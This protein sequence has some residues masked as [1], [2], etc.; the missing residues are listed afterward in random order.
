MSSKDDRCGTLHPS[1]EGV[2]C[3]KDGEG[4]RANHPEH[5]ALQGE[6]WIDWP[7]DAHVAPPK[8]K[9]SRQWSGKAKPSKNKGLLK[10]MATRTMDEHA[11]A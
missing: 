5:T 4:P 10:E 9:E 11:E 8:R 6:T 3:E 7:N 2:R 1:I